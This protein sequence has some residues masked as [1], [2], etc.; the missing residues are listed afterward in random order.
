VRQAAIASCSPRIRVCDGGARKVYSWTD[1]LGRAGLLAD[2]I[3]TS[4]GVT[5]MAKDGHLCRSLLERQIDDFF[6]GHG[7][8]H[9]PEPH[10]LYDPDI[11]PDMYRADWR[12]AD[13]TYVEA[14]GFTANPVYMAKAQRK[15][16]LAE[17]HQIPV[18]TRHRNRSAELALH[19]RQMA[20]ARS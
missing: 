18:V 11:N 13:C 9:H 14:L 16:A 3:R 4:R 6:F 7:I 8:A 1:W 20:S 2:G 15:I 19:L 10:Y 12:L 5:A 17:Q